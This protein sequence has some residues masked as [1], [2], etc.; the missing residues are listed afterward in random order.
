MIKIVDVVCLLFVSI[1]WF[2]FEEEGDRDCERSYCFL[3]NFFLFISDCKL[4][5]LGNVFGVAYA[6]ASYYYLSH[7]FCFSPNK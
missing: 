2:V 7:L 4:H 1:F 6:L 5:C 3:L